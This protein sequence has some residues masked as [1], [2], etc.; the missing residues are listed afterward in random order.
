MDFLPG[1]A[2]FGSRW[3]E[4]VA[5]HFLGFR[6]HDRVLD[7][8]CGCGAITMAMAPDVGS[9]VGVDISAAAIELAKRIAA[10][11]GIANAHFLPGDVASLST[12]VGE[13]KFD[14]AYCLDTLEHAEDF[15]AI[16]GE[17]RRALRPGGR[18]FLL[19]PAEEGHGHFHY[20][21]EQV[22]EIAERT[23]WRVHF[24]GR[25]SPPFATRTF[26]LLYLKG[27][28]WIAGEGEKH[29]DVCHETTMFSFTGSTP[30]WYLRTWAAAF[31]LLW[32]ATCVFDKKPYRVGGSH[33]A[34]LLE[35]A[36]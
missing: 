35:H 34:S 14:M 33:I 24:L 10:S 6:R 1:E 2:H 12:I 31:P 18:F 21:P 23:G 19:V 5:R 4:R 25:L 15:P 20:D 3:R 30:P 16:L 27:R 32:W 26:H 36:D 13:R 29:V 7:A 8:G 28:H 22:R 9:I 17:V 11:R